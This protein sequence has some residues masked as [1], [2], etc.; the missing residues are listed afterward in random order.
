LNFSALVALS[1]GLLP[2]LAQQES[3]ALVNISSGLALTPKKSS[4]VYCATKAAVRSFTRTLKYQCEDAQ[5]HVKIIEA[6][7]PLVDTGMTA[8]RGS[9][10]ISAAQCATEIISGI[11]AGSSEIYV[12]KSKLLRLVL[13]VLPSA[14][15]KIMRNS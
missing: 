14:A 4:P 15:Y 10:K 2:L 7:P 11:E 12:G 6:L 1:V 8:G 5:P 9:G 13:R 3:A